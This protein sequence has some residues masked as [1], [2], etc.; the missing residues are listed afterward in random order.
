[1]PVK[2]GLPGGKALESSYGISNQRQAQFTKS[3]I[4]TVGARC[5]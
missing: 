4:V 3:F 1:M 2:I 5:F